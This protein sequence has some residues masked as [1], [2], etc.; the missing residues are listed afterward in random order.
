ME[1]LIR[2]TNGNTLLK[3]DSVRGT[4]GRG[5]F[6]TGL[7]WGEYNRLLIL[8]LGLENTDDDNA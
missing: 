3:I 4:E 6:T 2:D 1:L 7:R 8:T 5:V